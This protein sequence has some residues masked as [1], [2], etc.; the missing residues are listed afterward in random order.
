MLICLYNN[1]KIV[2]GFLSLLDKHI[3]ESLLT[4]FS[5]GMDFLTDPS[6]ELMNDVLI[7]KGTVQ[8]PDGR[9]I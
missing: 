9:L 1:L 2:P 4:N 8:Q 6:L 5:Q 7:C 3:K